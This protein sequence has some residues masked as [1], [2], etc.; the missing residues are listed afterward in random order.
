MWKDLKTGLI[1]IIVMTIFLGLGGL[2]GSA[3][4]KF[5]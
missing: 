1:A 5:Q 4:P 3:P 2:N